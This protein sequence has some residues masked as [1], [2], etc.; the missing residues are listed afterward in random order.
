MNFEPIVKEEAPAA[1]PPDPMIAVNAQLAE[2]QRQISESYRHNKGYDQAPPQIQYVPYAV[3][4]P[5]VEQPVTEADI[6]AD[7]PGTINRIAEQ[8]AA[9]RDSALREEL[10]THLGTIYE[11]D[12][13]RD[14]RDLTAHPYYRHVAEDL[15]ARV[16]MSGNARY[17]PGWLMDEF[18]KLVGA[19]AQDIA[20][21]T[22]VE[23]IER[24]RSVDPGVPISSSPVPGRSTSKETVVLD[25]EREA[26]RQYSNEMWGLH[27]SPEEWVAI[28][29]GKHFPARGK[30]MEGAGFSIKKD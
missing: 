5:Q 4:A 17:N 21:A 3:P 16:Q 8:R 1:A 13:E 18:H 22:Q 29:S 15:A 2:M 20:S 27:M 19:K 9:E 26:L 7:L 6:L 24:T 28:E 23:T 10:G 11:K 12:F 14:L 25:D 30:G